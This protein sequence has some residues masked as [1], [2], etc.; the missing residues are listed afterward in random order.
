MTMERPRSFTSS[1]FPFE[2]PTTA[3]T[4]C[5]IRATMQLADAEVRDIM[6]FSSL[7]AADVPEDWP[8]EYVAG[9]ESEGDDNWEN[10][11]L[12]Q[13]DHSEENT[14]VGIAGMKVLTSKQ[15]TLQIGAALLS[16]YHG[17]H[18]GQEV[19]ATFGHWA[20]QHAE[21]DLVI[22]DVPDDHLASQKSL[23]RAGFTKTAYAPGI[24]FTRFELR[25]A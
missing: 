17:Q 10:F 25:R 7:L 22:C 16:A 4:L 2:Y 5:L 9:P 21:I 6:R 11:Y 18:L 8:P 12:V 20:F 14:V 19:A 24:G 1:A 13:T 15:K 3:G 23:Q